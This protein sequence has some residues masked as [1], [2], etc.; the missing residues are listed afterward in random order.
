MGLG[1]GL[2]S[3][4]DRFEDYLVNK[5]G[6]SPS[7]AWP[8]APQSPSSLRSGCRLCAQPVTAQLL[9]CPTARDLDSTGI[10]P[11][12]RMEKTFFLSATLLV[13]GELPRAVGA[14]IPGTRLQPS[15]VSTAGLSTQLDRPPGRGQVQKAAGPCAPSAVQ[16][17]P[18]P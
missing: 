5:V 2:G 9:T 15:A 17:A 8:P 7:S 14:V 11:G 18:M 13:A 1:L 6:G 10:V 4:A 16:G 12:F 3:T